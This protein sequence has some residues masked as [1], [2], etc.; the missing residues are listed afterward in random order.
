MVKA[1]QEFP[2]LEAIIAEFLNV[3]SIRETGDGGYELDTLWTVGG[4]VNH[5]GH[6][7]F[8]QNQYDATITIVPVDG[9]W[10]IRGLE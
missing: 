4:S 3:R 6:I 8:R 9:T 7:H 10:K 2:S 5:F 1:S